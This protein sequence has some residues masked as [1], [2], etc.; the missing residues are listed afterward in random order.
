MLLLI[1]QTGQINIKLVSLIEKTEYEK[2]PDNCRPGNRIS[3][4]Q[5]V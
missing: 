3:V 2:L 1:L 5:I 4:V